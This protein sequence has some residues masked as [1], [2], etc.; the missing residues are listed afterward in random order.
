MPTLE[1]N[2]LPANQGDDP[3][4]ILDQQMSQL[5]NNT[6]QQE[7]NIRRFTT[8]KNAYVNR[9]YQLQNDYDE[10]RQGILSMRK[11]LE[12]VQSLVSQGAISSDEGKK[13]MWRMVLPQETSR[14]MFPTKEIPA[15]PASQ[16]S[17]EVQPRAEK[18]SNEA[19]GW[20]K[21]EQVDLIPK[22]QEFRDNVALVFGSP[23]YDALSPI[24]KRQIDAQWDL[25]Q[26]SLKNKWDPES[27]S[28]KSL[29]AEGTLTKAAA[30][31]ISPMAAS[32]QKEAKKNPTLKFSPE[33]IFM[34]GESGLK[35]RELAKQIKDRPTQPEP[36]KKILTAT[37]PRTG[38][39]IQSTD[40]GKTWQP[41]K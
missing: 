31:L 11:D 37:N 2:Q 21:K 20:G 8:D 5:K 18:Y 41:I 23:S 12:R 15:I 35:E 1:F 24:E 14:A 29:R 28:I 40:N 36:G 9:I 22:Y 32:V 26:K 30:K 6:R 3:F 4:V 27:A 25:T 38:Q 33:E 17:T 10:K 7:M 13:A 16:L 19:K 39:R 34:Y